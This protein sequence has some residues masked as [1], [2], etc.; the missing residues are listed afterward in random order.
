MAA[1][2]RGLK[3]GLSLLVPQATSCTQLLGSV[4]HRVPVRLHGAA[5]EFRCSCPN[6]ETVG[7]GSREEITEFVI[8][9]TKLRCSHVKDVSRLPRWWNYR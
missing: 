4:P 1:V 6:R 8:R 5:H 9:I 7:A 2:D 3:F